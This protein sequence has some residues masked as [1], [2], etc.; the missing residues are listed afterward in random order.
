MDLAKRP[1]RFPTA[2]PFLFFTLA[3]F[4]LSV[5]GVLPRRAASFAQETSSGAAQP[6]QSSSELV[7]LDVSV[8]DRKGQ[9]YGG[10]TRPDFRVADNGTEK[11]VQFFDSVAA[12]EHVLV[13]VETSPA[14]YLIHEQHLQAL[15]YLLEG[16]SP[17][18][19]AALAT[20]GDRAREVHSFTAK[21]AELE[22]AVAEPNYVIGMDRL[23]FFDS[24]RAVMD[25]FPA[26]PEKKAIVALTTG[27]DTSAPAEWDALDRK[28]RTSDVVV[29]SVALGGSLRGDSP[30]DLSK[31]PKK[32][33]KGQAP[34]AGQTPA[35]ARADEALR[36]LAQ[37]TGG[38]AYF[39]QAPADF[40]AEYREIASIL[41]H[42][43]VL[44]IAPDHDG[45]FH[46]LSVEIDDPG[47][48]KKVDPK[49]PAY[50]TFYRE[51]YLA[52]GS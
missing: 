8:L 21:K 50:R 23:N 4:A 13:L 41:R 35:F 10:L 22:H 36:S 29:F 51:G 1:R 30:A 45:A 12:P 47:A 11:P 16:L 3:I 24:L 52:P 17:D 14:V 18:D 32:K 38:R 26:G 48:T 20:Y 39:P 5:T 27:L 37:I 9:F 33:K 42:Q 2:W 6:I 40:V 44:G 28:L 49:K 43:Y 46:K 34:A 19:K 15:S 25:W 31:K 7:L